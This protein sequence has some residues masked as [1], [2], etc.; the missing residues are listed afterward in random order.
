M[1]GTFVAP[2]LAALLLAASSVAPAASAHE[3]HDAD[4]EPGFAQSFAALRAQD[5]RVEEIAFR[6]RSGNAPFCERT[7]LESGI[8]LDDAARYSNPAALRSAAGIKGDIFVQ[9]VVPAGP[10][11]R[12]GVRAGDE[13]HSVAGTDIASHKFDGAQPWARIAALNARLDA[14]GG[15]FSLGISGGERDILIKPVPACTGWVEIITGYDGASTDGARISIGRDFVGLA[16]SDEEL[17][18]VIA[19]ELAHIV[20]DHPAWLDT[21]GRKRRNIRQTEREADRLMP[22]LLANA[23]Y[24][25]AAAARFMQRWGPDNNGGLRLWRKHDGWDERLELI[26]A[27]L[28][29]VQ[30]SVQRHGHADWKQDFAP[31]FDRN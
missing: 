12:A 31:Q 20:L 3:V 2:A 22:W 1:R 13:V 29:A 26:E 4:T 30:T 10:A 19:H 21:R 28:A 15:P 25:P 7:E 27:E 5:W 16:Y 24:D 17:A 8:L 6:L 23:G 18:A 9:A 11:D 14:F